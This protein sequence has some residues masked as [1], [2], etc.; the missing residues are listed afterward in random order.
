MVE[1]HPEQWN[2]D[3]CKLI[4]HIDISPAEVDEHYIVEAGVLGDLGEAL[5]E[6]ML[7]G[8]DGQVL[9]GTL[10][11]YAVMRATDLTRPAWALYRNSLLYLALLFDTG[12][13]PVFSD[14]VLWL[15]GIAGV[16]PFAAAATQDPVGGDGDPQS[17]QPDGPAGVELG[18]LDPRLGVA[19]RQPHV[20]GRALVA[21]GRRNRRMDGEAALVGEGEPELGQRRRPFVA[22]MGHRPQVGGGEVAAAVR[23]VGRGRDG[24]G[25]G[26]PHCR[27]RKRGGAKRVRHDFGAGAE[28]LQ[29]LPVRPPVGQKHPLGEA[30][31]EIVAHLDHA[32]QRRGARVG[33]DALVGGRGEVAE[34]EAG[35]IVARPDDAVE[36]DLHR[37]HLSVLPPGIRRRARGR[38]AARSA[39]RASRLPGRDGG[40]RSRRRNP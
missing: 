16:P 17:A 10:M 18:H 13:Y 21:E 7:Y 15:L 20:V 31:A 4:V 29:P 11:N 2:P 6:Q 8:E 30:E 33:D 37:A 40:G 9:T 12:T 5:R 39:R 14:E 32:L 27:G 24:G 36:I 25:V 3:C 19:G 22:A 34:A 35:I 23:R 38:A 28:R 26:G 1:Y